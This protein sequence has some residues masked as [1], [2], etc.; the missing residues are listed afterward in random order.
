LLHVVNDQPRPPRQLNDKVPRD[1]ETICLKAM[2]KASGRRYGTARDLAGD[3]WRFLAGEPILA[4]PAGVLERLGRWSRRNPVAA[5]LLIAVTLGSAIG[6]V[7]LSNLSQW[8]VQQSALDSAAQLSLVL[9]EANN[10]YSAVVE[11]AED[12]AQTLGFELTHNVPP[13]PGKVALVVP[14]RFTHNLGRRVTDA[15]ASG[16][17]VRL[18]SDFPFPWRK[19]EGGPRDRF[20]AD[21]LADLR[22]HPDRP[23]FEFTDLDDRPV[24]RYAT[25]RV[26]KQSCLKCHNEHPQSEKRD[27]REGDVRGVLEIIRP[28]DGDEARIRAGLRWT[29]I[30]VAAVSV[31]LLGLSVGVLLVGN[32]PRPRV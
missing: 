26:M 29:F 7:H 1:L 10:E 27:W 20:E 31:T 8:L 6:L 28:L 17:R 32:R 19:A 2:A 23:V 3:L 9:D 25:A 15:S 18:Y 4:R 14:A 11:G 12:Q 30:L 5:G 24:L 16:V 13:E 21:A 22:L